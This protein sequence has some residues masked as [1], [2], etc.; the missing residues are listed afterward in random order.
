MRN[1]I[2]QVDKVTEK[3]RVKYNI[4]KSFYLLA[5]LTTLLYVIGVLEKQYNLE[6]I[7][8]I[9]VFF[10]ME[11]FFLT[12]VKKYFLHSIMMFSFF[13]FLLGRPILS[14][15][16]GYAWWEGYESVIDIVLMILLV[17]LVSFLSGCLLADKIS[18]SQKNKDKKMKYYA[19]FKS[20]YVK[21]GSITIYF[22]SLISTYYIEI[23][24]FI[25]LHNKN[26]LDLYLGNNLDF[27]F[28]IEILS[29][30][31]VFFLAIVLS[32][33]YGKKIS[34]CI[35]SLYVFTGL[36]EFLLGN[37]TSL[38]AKVLF[39]FIYYCIRNFDDRKKEQWIGKYEKAIIIIMV[40]ICIISLGIMNYT[41]S[42][43]KVEQKSII[44]IASDFFYKQG[45]TFETLCQGVDLTEELKEA[46]VN[47]TFGPFFDYL[48]DST[49]S[50]ILFNTEPM[51]EGN[52][53]VR[54]TESHDMSHHLSYLVMGNDY[55]EGH[56]RGSSF[57]LE[58]YVDYGYAGIAVYLIILGAFCTKVISIKKNQYLYILCIIVLTDIFMIT[59]SSALGGMVFIIQPQFWLMWGIVLCL[60]GADRLIKKFITK[61]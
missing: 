8:V 32:Y 18:I 60:Y 57:V 13:L 38:M 23:N 9:I 21:Y 54:A 51:P 49:L 5:I 29:G 12:N 34:F 7:A 25:F 31:L 39:A 28:Y 56:G 30:S 1:M 48:N 26:Y 22:F 6:L 41:R 4:H 43:E 36:F 46:E 19:I 27:P 47:Y 35:L 58:L 52:N 16:R 44:A 15:I 3:I 10:E 37:R 53:L 40:P 11:R 2:K 59:R 20:K 61:N 42:D 33:D 50:Q 17:M 14:F 24:R 55:L 45:T